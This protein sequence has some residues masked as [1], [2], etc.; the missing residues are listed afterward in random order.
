MKSYSYYNNS[1]LPINH[2][3]HKLRKPHFDKH[4]HHINQNGKEYLN[5]TE[6]QRNHVEIHG[7]L[8]ENNYFVT[9]TGDTVVKEVVII[10]Y[11]KL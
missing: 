5:H 3:P 10:N 1:Q 2:L 9:S 6:L 7:K 8:N 11:N 4:Y